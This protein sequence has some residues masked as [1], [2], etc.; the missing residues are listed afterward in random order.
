MGWL[1]KYQNGG[2]TVLQKGEEAKYQKW[3][4]SLP[5][6]LQYEEDYDLKGFWKENPTWSPSVPGAH[7]TD[8]YKLPNHP[9]F[10]N[11]SVYFNNATKDRAGHWLETDSSWN[12]IPYNP[13]VKDTIIERKKYGGYSTTGYKAD[14]PDRNNPYNIIPSGRITMQNVPHPVLGID[15]FGN[16]QMMQPGGEYQFQGDR[17]FEVPAMQ[18]GG[19]PPIYVDSINDPRYRAYQDS[20]GLYNRGVEDNKFFREHSYNTPIRKFP[21]SKVTSYSVNANEIGKI[22]PISAYTWDNISSDHPDY[23]RAHW[24]GYKKP[25]QQV[26]LGQQINKLP[27]GSKNEAYSP[28]PVSVGAYKPK[29][30]G[31]WYSNRVR[32]PIDTEDVSALYNEDGTPKYTQEMK[33][34]GIPQRY[35]NMG[36]SRVGQKKSGDGQHKW[37]VL[38][39]KGDSYKVVQGGYRGMQDFKQ[40]HSEERKDRFWNRM[41]GRDSSKAKDPFSPLYWHKRFGTWEYGGWLQQ[42]QDGGS[43]QAHPEYSIVD[44]LASQGQDYSKGHRAELAQQYGVQGYDY[45]AEKNLELLSKLKTATSLPQKPAG[46]PPVFTEL[47]NWP[48]TKPVPPVQ[49]SKKQEAF[50]RDEART[51]A[52]KQAAFS[53]VRYQGEYQGQ[54]TGRISA[55]VPTY[56]PFANTHYLGEY[57]GEPTGRPVS[58]KTQ[59]EP[60]FPFSNV[61]YQGEYMGQP[62]GRVS[63]PAPVHIPF[64]DTQYQG[65]YQ[66]QV[67]RT[68]APIEQIPDNLFTPPS[69]YTW[70][71]IANNVSNRNVPLSTTTKK[72]DTIIEDATKYVNNK[73]KSITKKSDKFLKSIN[74][75]GPGDVV[76]IADN[77]L[78]RQLIKNDP[79]LLEPSSNISIP[80]DY[81]PAI[82]VG[83]TIPENDRKIHQSQIVDLNQVKFGVRNR[84]EYIP[85]EGDGVVTTFSP[86]QKASKYFSKRKDPANASYIGVD[87]DG[88]IK[89]GQRK[90]FEGKEF[91][92]TRTFENK[93]IDF[94]KEED[95]K[96]KLVKADPKASKT[97][98]SPSIKVLDDNGKNIEGKLSLLVPKNKITNT[99]GSATGGRYII[100]KQSGEQY[101]ISG[102]LD[103]LSKAFYEI[104]GNDPY[105]NVYTLDNGSYSSGLQTRDKKITQEDLKNYDLQNTSGGNFAYI[106]PGNYSSNQNKYKEY[107]TQTPNVRTEKDESYKK[108]HSL[109][110]EQSAIILHHTGFTEPDMK[111]VNSIFMTPGKESSHV[112]INF[113]G[114]RYRYANP[115]QVTFHA[116]ESSHKGRGNVNDFGIGIEFQGDTNKKPLTDAQINSFVEYALPLIKA[117]KIKLS[118]ITTHHKIAPGRK[119]DITD[120]EYE[121]IIKRLK[122]E[123]VNENAKYEYGG[124]VEMQ[125]G[126]PRKDLPKNLIPPTNPYQRSHYD[127]VTGK[128]YLTADQ[129]NNPDVYNHESFHEFQD[130]AGRL[131][132]PEM[133]EGPLKR[134]AMVASDA[135]QRAYFNRQDLD[136]NIIGNRFLQTH[137]EFQF[138]PGQVMYEKYIDPQKYREPWT[139]E[140]EA[141]DYE[142]Y[143][144]NKGMKNGGMIKRA[145]GSYSKRGLW[146]N[147]RANAGS[148]K[149][150]TKEMLQ[151]ERKIRS[152]EKK[153]YGGWLNEYQ[154]GGVATIDSNTPTGVSV[155]T[156]TYQDIEH[157]PIVSSYAPALTPQEIFAKQMQAKQNESVMREYRPISPAYREQLEREYKWKEAKQNVV[158]PLLQ[159]A[160]VVTDVMQLGNF[161]PHPIAQGI[162]K[163]GNVFGTGVDALQA[164]MDLGDGNYGSAAINAGSMLVPIGLESQVFRRNSKYLRPGQPLYP[165]SPQAMGSKKRVQYLEPFVYTRHM[166]PGNLMANRALLGTLATETAVDATQQYGGWLN[167]YQ[168]GGIASIDNP[169]SKGTSVGT[170]AYQDWEHRPMPAPYISDRD[171]QIQ[172]LRMQQANTPAIGAQ[173]TW[174]QKVHHTT[175]KIARAVAP[176]NYAL[177]P[178][179]LMYP[180]NAVANLSQP[181][182]YYEGKQGYA[183]F[184]GYN[185]MVNDI[186]AVAPALK[187]SKNL[188]SKGVE[189]LYNNPAVRNV[190]DNV[191]YN[192]V[193]KIS[194][195][196]AN[197]KY[198]QPYYKRAAYNA[199]TQSGNATRDWS[200]VIKQVL[201]PGNY[202]GARSML[203]PFDNSRDLPKLYIY[204]DESN[205]VKNELQ[206]IGAERYEKKY[207]PLNSYDLEMT[208]DPNY[209]GFTQEA[210]DEMQSKINKAIAEKGVYAKGVGEG[211]T[212]L[213]YYIPADDI[214]GHMN[215]VYK[216]PSGAQRLRIQDIWKFDPDD[217]AKRWSSDVMNPKG[218]LKSRIQ[219]RLVE[220][221]GKPF[222]LSKDYPLELI[223]DTEKNIAK[224]STKNNFENA[225]DY[226]INK[227]IMDEFLKKYSTYKKY[228]GWLK[229]Y[230]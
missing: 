149:K 190:V 106:K 41:G 130:R 153:E 167:S 9:T 113:D 169:K 100:K 76:K 182:K 85:I 196:P 75:E 66:G 125:D 108:G 90:D 94:N 112:V 123:G 59:T 189:Q 208:R 98:F 35:K 215:Y 54:S 209:K 115:D 60:Y 48:E 202:K 32:V 163:V 78:Q 124:P 26:I 80:K 217:Y 197:N 185:N 221:A 143:M 157:K 82:I 151:Q 129:Y 184:E 71:P 194:D 88:N 211:S 16:K 122:K 216:D 174:Q 74:I 1:K 27:T 146:D 138:V 155:G 79:N 45:S 191:A 55:P 89:V 99:F 13:S 49:V 177:I 14:S 218:G 137:P 160:D 210:I 109:K 47:M 142:N 2:G 23:Y 69:E 39:K 102:S 28:I 180:A 188:A 181:S 67:M 224:M 213:K 227:D 52:N 207:G 81:K 97:M 70:S 101:L 22:K 84:G 44:Y 10:S 83:S 86:F 127:H 43:T 144:H 117:K 4:S 12:Y 21:F 173:P 68:P 164:G 64:A 17:V 87:D 7:M 36:F 225:V 63:I 5:T 176:G 228:G 204:G 121:R 18:R 230:K 201:K 206:P 200:N 37:K 6:R 175:G 61:F 183:G 34:G 147:I 118:D 95:G 171:R 111:G 178:E 226:S 214:A 20:L 166:T 57:Q 134:P 156:Q 96:I 150:P 128:M 53:N 93:I 212:S 159:G 136:A 186:S 15:N 132:V 229:K 56:T 222:I 30:Q 170:Q 33:E 3:K 158:K 198:L 135:L 77:Y 193:D 203:R 119:P 38:A 25:E 192:V 219:A 141:V 103:D 172:A 133:W 199:M 29:I 46:A 51:A 92:I 168:K 205:F 145:D 161:I 114:T 152:A 91:N 126:G 24:F 120:S 50:N 65:E 8:K 131:S 11:E 116:G 140:G 42:Y 105:L 58:L 110:N 72:E 223:A 179:M 148:G 139:V 104:K 187:I 31:E 107:Y 73:I 165:F 195:I 40:H 162:G 154:S 220:K 62:T 19:V